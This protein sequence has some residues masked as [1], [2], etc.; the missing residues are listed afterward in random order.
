MREFLMLAHT[1]DPLKHQIAG[2]YAS[3]KLDGQ[4]C[5]WDGGVSR[6]VPTKE[7]PWANLSKKVRPVATGLW[8]RYGNVIVAPDVWLDRLPNHV[9]L[10]GE[11][12]CGNLQLL[13]TIVSRDVADVHDWLNVKYMVFDSPGDDVFHTGTINNVNFKKEIDAIKCVAFCK[14]QGLKEVLASPFEVTVGKLE[15]ECEGYLEQVRLPASERLARDKLYEML[16]GVVDAGGE[17]MIL[18]DPRSFWFPKRNNNLLKVKPMLDSEAMVVG[19]DQGKDRLEGMLGALQVKWNINGVDRY[20]NLG[21]G[22][23]D[24]ERDASLYPIGSLVTF[25]YTSLTNDGV[26]REARF[27]RKS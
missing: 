15:R 18:R 11:L 22:F 5:F 10:D 9:F 4:R 25:K 24:A 7:V 26:P 12:Y 1:F 14:R 23:T 2:W 13:R 19:Y 27:W 6:G 16:N 17:G 3:E 20:F 8:S 21:T